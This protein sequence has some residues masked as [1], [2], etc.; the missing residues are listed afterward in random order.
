MDNKDS[1]MQEKIN[2]GKLTLVEFFASWCIH[3]Q[4]M[5]P[6]VEKFKEEMA[7]KVQVVQVDIDKYE[8][9]ATDYEIE[10]TPTFILIEN[11]EQLWKEAG[12]MSLQ[13]LKDA[14]KEFIK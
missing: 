3:C 7:G 13:E 11:G 2:S 8:Q 6:I 9:L 14:V 5:A 12:E 4:R 10:G 1:E